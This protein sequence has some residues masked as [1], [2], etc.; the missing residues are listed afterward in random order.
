MPTKF[1]ATL[2]KREIIK[3]HVLLLQDLQLRTLIKIPTPDNNNKVTST[4]PDNTRQINANN[5]KT[6]SHSLIRDNS[7]S[8][9]SNI[10]R[11]G[12]LSKTI[13]SGLE[14]INRSVI[15]ELHKITIA[16]GLYTLIPREIDT[17]L[18]ATGIQMS[19][20]TLIRKL[21]SKNIS[22]FTRTMRIKEWLEGKDWTHLPN[23]A[24]NLKKHSSVRL[25]RELSEKG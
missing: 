23:F 22:I 25:K 24:A 16:A 13:T 9:I 14:A 3:M 20:K 17:N 10:T 6:N 21:D 8:K 19:N 4:E 11:L 7:S 18:R 1:L 12:A 2:K 15:R 5:N